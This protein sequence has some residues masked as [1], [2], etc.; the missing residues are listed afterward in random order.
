M[1]VWGGSPDAAGSTPG[2]TTMPIDE[3]EN[4]SLRFHSAGSTATPCALTGMPAAGRSRRRPV[5]RA[6]S[7]VVN[8]SLG[9]GSRQAVGSPGSHEPGAVDTVGVASPATPPAL[10]PSSV[11]AEQ[12][13]AISEV[14]T[15]AAASRRT[16]VRRDWVGTG[17]S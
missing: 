2:T 8:R 15:I 17:R 16:D 6:G 7:A 1:S 3:G 4:P 12:A 13:A 5:G 14:A 10:P 11:P 9:Q